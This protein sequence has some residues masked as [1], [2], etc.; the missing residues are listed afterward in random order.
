MEL[1]IESLTLLKV[2][3]NLGG[4]SKEFFCGEERELQTTPSRL[5]LARIMLET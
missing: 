3:P 2:N 1:S 4:L 5:K